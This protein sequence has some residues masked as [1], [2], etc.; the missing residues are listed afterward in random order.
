MS[1]VRSSTF[2]SS[3]DPSSAVSDEAASQT[4]SGADAHTPKLDSDALRAVSEEISRD[5]AS[6]IE[7]TALVLYDRDPAHLQA[8]WYVT[9]EELAWARGAFPGGGAGVRQVLRLCRLDQDGRSEVVASAYQRT[10]RLEREG[11]E[12]FPLPEEGTE[13]ECELGL[14][15]DG[16]GWLM[17]ARSNRI[18]LTDRTLPS[19]AFEPVPI[20]LPVQSAE[21]GNATKYQDLETIP[22]EAAL[23]AGGE[24]L[25]PVFP[26]LE[27]EE[28][29]APERP[30]PA[31][32]LLGKAQAPDQKPGYPSGPAQQTAPDLQ[33]GGGS[34]EAALASMPPPLLPSSQGQPGKPGGLPGALYDPRA[35]L[36]SAALR[37][38]P[39]PGLGME[40]EA[41]LIVRGRT[42]PGSTVELFGYLV[43]VGEDGRFYIRRPVEDP[44]LLSLA[45]IRGPKP[46]QGDPESE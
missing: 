2:D 6:Q 15:S 34:V 36:S 17:L 39:P 32:E 41:E 27:P 31:E 18:R 29:R 20:N 25:Y 13:Y 46:G 3:S 11:L 22:V 14:E 19:S 21:Q 38:V 35:A 7:Q 42:H 28:M 44:K 23:A 33:P 12:G 10:G 30:F 43:P 5:F 45:T 24:P 8:Q 4:G 9:P 40:I 37:G 26:N 1:A 16:G